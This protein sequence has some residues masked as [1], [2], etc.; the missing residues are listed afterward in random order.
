L[1][2]REEINLLMISGFVFTSPYEKGL[3]GPVGKIIID[4]H[5]TGSA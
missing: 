2:K 1:Q 4:L 5:C 3:I